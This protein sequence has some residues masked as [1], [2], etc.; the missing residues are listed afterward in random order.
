MSHTWFCYESGVDV[1]WGC[2]FRSVQN[3]ILAVTS[4]P[5]RV[6]SLDDLRRAMWGPRMAPPVVRASTDLWIEPGNAAER[7]RSWLPSPTVPVLVAIGASTRPV[8]NACRDRGLL[9]TSSPS[10]Y[11]LTITDAGVLA[12][13]IEAHLGRPSTAIVVDDGVYATTWIERDG[14]VISVD[15][16]TTTPARAPIP[17][18]SLADAIPRFPS[19][20]MCLWVG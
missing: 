14:V 1:G 20:A 2:V 4:D 8:W 17:L 13:A 16:H 11:E 15:P 7:F 19:F 6:P 12:E 9:R 10:Q 3:A 5:S 18:G